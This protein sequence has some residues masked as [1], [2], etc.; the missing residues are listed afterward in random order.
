MT[1]PTRSVITAAAVLCMAT[2]SPGFAERYFVND[3]AACPTNAEEQDR[4]MDFAN[5]G[6]L[7]L[8]EDG[9]SSMEY[10]CSFEPDLQYH[11]DGYQVTTH[12]GHCQTPGPVF[13]PTLF[14]FVMTEEAPGEIA[15]FD[16]NEYTTRFYSCTD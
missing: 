2:T 8:E 4:L 1:S 6:G 7:I 5:D 10:F 3:P 11:W 13:M 12:V 15:L 14:T 16:S 9:F